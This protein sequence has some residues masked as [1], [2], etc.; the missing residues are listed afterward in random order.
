[1]DEVTQ[2]VLDELKPVPVHLESVTDRR[3]K[4]TMY[5]PVSG[6]FYSILCSTVSWG[7]TVPQGLCWNQWDSN[8]KGQGKQ[9]HSPK[10]EAPGGS[11]PSRRI[12]YSEGVAGCCLV[13]CFPR[14]VSLCPYSSICQFFPQLCLLLSLMCTE[15]PSSVMLLPGAVPVS[16]PFR[17]G[18]PSTLF[19]HRL[20]GLLGSVFWL[21]VPLS[22]VFS[23]S[24]YR[25]SFPVILLCISPLPLS[26]GCGIPLPFSPPLQLRSSV[27]L[28]TFLSMLCFLNP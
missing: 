25:C 5:W 20:G 10:R 24:F 3:P 26:F 11:S 21:L 14:P 2:A 27:V 28:F 18:R 12:A 6:K 19:S 4:M 9:R 22:S 23:C 13:F 17:G 7:K 15:G 1:M 8:G 16:F